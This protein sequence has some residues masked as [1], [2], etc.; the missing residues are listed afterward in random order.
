MKPMQGRMQTIE[1]ELLAHGHDRAVV[2]VTLAAEL[3]LEFGLRR[4]VWA[5]R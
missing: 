4:F 5:S 2:D 1:I 3:G